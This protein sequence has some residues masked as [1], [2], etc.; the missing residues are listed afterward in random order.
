MLDFPHQ[1]KNTGTGFPLIKLLTNG[2]PLGLNPRIITRHFPACANPHGDPFREFKLQ[3]ED[4]LLLLSH[5]VR[6]G[7]RGAAP[8]PV[9]LLGGGLGLR[10]R[11]Q[12]LRELQARALR[13][14]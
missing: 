9:G 11:S 6:R 5:L 8:L 4:F 14:G 12:Q 3:S 10:I 2:F 1:S 13:R 7:A